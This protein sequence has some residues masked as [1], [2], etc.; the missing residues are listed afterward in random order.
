M[1]QIGRYEIQK[2]LGRG[3]MGVVYAAVDPVIG[4]QVAIKT[5]RLGALDVAANRAELTQ[6]LHREARAAGILS[7]PG[8]I[9]VFDVG[10]QG[11]D[12]YIVM[13]FID[14][15]TVEEI[16]DAGIQQHSGT[17]MSILQKAASAL[18]YAHTKGI[19]HRDIK[20]SN[21][22]VCPDGS[23][24]VADFG[25][26]KL[27]VSTALT[28]SGFVLGTPSYM[29]PEQAQGRA[30][31]GRS[32]QFS[33]AVVAYRLLSGKLPFEGPTLTALLSKI[34][35]EEPEYESAG[36]KPPVRMVFEKALSKDPQ[37]RY[38]NCTE[39][40]RELEEAHAKSKAQT[41]DSALL[42]KEQAAASVVSP[43]PAPD[44]VSPAEA[45]ATVTPEIKKQSPRRKSTMIAWAVAI[46][47]VVLS[48]IAF[49]VIRA[50]R[51]MEPAVQN[52]QADAVA[53]ATGGTVAPAP[54]SEPS[55]PSEKED[56][57][58]TPQPAPAQAKLDKVIAPE[59]PA[60]KPKQLNVSAAKPDAASGVLTWSGNL[61]KNTLLVISEQTANIGSI[62]GQLPGK[63]V[64]IEVEPADL[65]IRQP[66]AEVNRWNQII[67]YSGNQRYSNIAILWKIRK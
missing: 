29:S 18:D 42:G 10:E 30:I 25:V 43:A 59:V 31:D 26:A 32:D 34:L 45:S 37:R 40:V 13:E 62:S 1:T 64:T 67:L 46:A 12:A 8:I 66:P 55:S 20:P 51:E 27:A 50:N 41:L 2:E 54:V 16:L 35:W 11:E 6:R 56:M 57:T 21:L 5:I 47:V 36:L 3:A 17:S 4:R 28:Q 58:S 49:L 14:G 39:F 38:P 60:P 24:K 33:L 53:P 9:T 19:I 15:K 23:V 63:P 65:I 61:E 22:M 52:L 44:S 7:H 48:V